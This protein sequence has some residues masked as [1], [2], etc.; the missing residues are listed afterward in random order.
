[1]VKDFY[2]K[3]PD[4]TIS[5]MDASGNK[6]GVIAAGWNLENDRVSIKVDD[7]KGRVVLDRTMKI[8]MFPYVP[9]DKQQQPVEQPAKRQSKRKYEE[10]VNLGSAYADSEER[11]WTEDPTPQGPYQIG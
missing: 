2:P 11:V 9:K 10:L 3:P 8:M 7:R 4:Y 6:L 1:V 5:A